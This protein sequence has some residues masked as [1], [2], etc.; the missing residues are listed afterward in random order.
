MPL[1]RI[2]RRIDAVILVRDHV[3]C[4]EF[5][6]GSRA[7]LSADVEQAVDYALCLRDFHSA[8][9]NRSITPVLCADQAA[10]EADDLSAPM[11]FIDQVASCRYVNGGAIKRA[12]LQVSSVASGEQIDWRA[13]DRSRYNPTPNIVAAARA[14]Y[15]GHSVEEIGRTDASAEQL[16]AVAE[17][18]EDIVEA[19]K[20]NKRHAICFVTGDPGTGKTL[21]G[22]DLVLSGDAGRMFGEPAVLLSGN[23]PLVH[24]LVEAIAE[25]AKARAGVKKTDIRREAKQA[26]QTLLDFLREYSDSTAAPPEHVVVFDEAQRAW[27]SAT[28]LKLMGRKKSEPQLFLEILGRQPWA[29]IVC[30]VGSG[31][32]IN[33]GEGGLALWGEAISELGEKWT[34][35][36]SP[37]A[38]A[39]SGI[40]TAALQQAGLT[41]T[42]SD[43]RLHLHGNLRAYRIASYGKW[44]EA[45]LAGDLDL[46]AGIARQM[47]S[48]PAVITRE[49]NVLKNWLRDRRR[50]GHRV[51]LL[52]SS[53]AVR[54]LAEGVPP[55]PRSNELDAVA[56]WFLKPSGDFRSSNALEKPLSEFVCQGLEI[57]YAGLLWGNDLIW[58]PNTNHVS[59][60]WIPRQMRAP[61]WTIRRSPKQAQYRLNAYRVLLTRSRAGM[62]IFVPQGSETDPTLDPLQFDSTFAALC[63][64]GC[65]PLN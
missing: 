3:V 60:K 24:V 34:A 49:L 53:G 59:G 10:M 32:E 36:G 37:S 43:E 29:C 42:A 17:K 48:A 9:R 33:R 11:R 45:V 35:Y 12:L 23:R 58:Q 5:K 7:F 20:E 51:G 38:S 39:K 50:G 2:G 62:G 47:G 6:I 21:L 30:L 1:L 64:A 14:V 4:I 61:A 55:S 41:S 40:R 46:A 22:L 15:A 13:F 56:H 26:L 19:A 44:V 31:Q 65:K 52:A 25:D 18:L 63:R 27:D 57:D 54:L 8:S 16:Q 28:G